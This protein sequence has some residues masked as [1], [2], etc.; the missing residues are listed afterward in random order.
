ML[1]NSSTGSAE[2]AVQPG[3]GRHVRRTKGRSRFLLVGLLGVALLGAAACGSSKAKNKASDTGVT[4][5]NV[6]IA[7]HSADLSGLIKAGVIKGVP[8]D[9]HTQNALRI[10]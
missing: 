7:I 9:A 10:S 8:E 6:K 4:E 1:H 5:T 2:S 3:G